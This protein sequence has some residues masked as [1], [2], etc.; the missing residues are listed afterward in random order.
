M[1]V[2]SQEGQ[3]FLEYILILAIIAAMAAALAAALPALGIGNRL[4][5]PVKEDFSRAYRY[6]HPKV[7]G[8]DEQDGPSMHPRIRDSFRIF[9]RPEPQ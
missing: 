2:R 1:V 6:G 3:A 5:R 4:I 8:P 7:K 9:V